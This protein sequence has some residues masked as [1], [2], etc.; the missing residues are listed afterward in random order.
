MKHSLS[1][2]AVLLTASAAT[3]ALTATTAAADARNA[4]ASVEN[5]HAVAGANPNNGQATNPA[6]SAAD[7]KVERLRKA[8]DKAR[9]KRADARAALIPARTALSDANLTTNAAEAAVLTATAKQHDAKAALTEART[10]LYTVRAAL[11]DA[12][13]ALAA[14]EQAQA[15]A[16][17]AHTTAINTRNDASTLLDSLNSQREDLENDLDVATTDLTN[18]ETTI[19]YLTGTQ[20]PQAANAYATKLSEVN[21]IGS[22]RTTAFGVYADRTK[23]YQQCQPINATTVDCM[24]NSGVWATRSEVSSAWANYK[25]FDGLYVTADAQLS[26][27][28]T[29]LTNLQNAHI[30]AELLREDRLAAKALA[31]SNLNDLDADR[32]AAYAA[33]VTAQAEV[34]KQADLLDTLP[35]EAITLT[36]HLATATDNEKAAI[37]VEATKAEALAVTVQTLADTMTALDALTDREALARQNFETAYRALLKAQDHARKIKER[38]TKARQRR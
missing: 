13:D 26:S 23:A 6:S 35:V 10:T 12:T 5:G 1:R 36:A 15:D 3:L 17:A 16:A 33:V 25:Y 20:I 37:A 2:A 11:K 38:L 28:N 30:D 31:Q 29:T 4:T 27:L 18:I 19:A 22:Q 8:L 34:N 24:D 7:A 21:S 9:A 14:N 32:D